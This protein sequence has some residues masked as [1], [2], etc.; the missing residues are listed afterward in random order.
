MAFDSAFMTCA[1]LPV[2]LDT[3]GGASVAQVPQRR[4]GSAL[5]LPLGAVRALS[6][7]EWVRFWSIHC[8]ASLPQ[9]DPDPWPSGCHASLGSQWAYICLPSFGLQ[10]QRLG[11]RAWLAAGRRAALRC[12]RAC[13]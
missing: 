4:P 7:L 13:A 6:L 12:L 1:G 2:G 9:L 11:R 10:C 8:S 5:E 3:S